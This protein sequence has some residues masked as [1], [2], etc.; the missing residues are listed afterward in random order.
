MLNSLKRQKQ[1]D[2]G[3]SLSPSVNLGFVSSKIPTLPNY[4]EYWQIWFDCT[5]RRKKIFD[6]VVFHISE[7][8]TVIFGTRLQ[9][10]YKWPIL[11]AYYFALV[12]QLSLVAVHSL[13]NHHDFKLFLSV[14]SVCKQ[15]VKKCRTKFKF[16]VNKEWAN[17][18]SSRYKMFT[19]EVRIEGQIEFCLILQ[20]LQLKGHTKKI[21]CNT[22]ISIACCVRQFV[23]DPFQLIFNHFFKQRF[24]SW[25]R[26]L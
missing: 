7:A 2:F 6:K 14:T 22:Q 3:L 23:F 5:T 19:G 24:G 18:Q 10:E 1:L 12:G 15:R 20:S 11:F 13:A 17:R 26:Q 8:I 25:S 21:L 9:H 16:F 4:E